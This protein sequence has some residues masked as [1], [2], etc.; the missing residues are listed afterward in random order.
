M[1]FLKQQLRTILFT[2]CYVLMSY[3]NVFCERIVYNLRIDHLRIIQ[4][5]SYFNVV[6]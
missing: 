2:F 1:S 4:E 6:L 5:L 3:L